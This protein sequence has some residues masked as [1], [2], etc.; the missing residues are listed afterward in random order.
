MIHE[1][2]GKYSILRVVVQNMFAISNCG[3]SICK[4][5]RHAYRP[6]RKALQ[7]VEHSIFRGDVLFKLDSALVE[8]LG[9]IPDT[10][11]KRSH[12]FPELLF[13]W[14]QVAFSIASSNLLTRTCQNKATSNILEIRTNFRTDLV[15]NDVQGTQND[16]LPIPAAIRKAGSR[17]F[18]HDI[19]N[20]RLSLQSVIFNSV[21]GTEKTESLN[22]TTEGKAMQK[23]HQIKSSKIRII[24]TDESLAYA[25]KHAYY[26]RVNLVWLQNDNTLASQ[27]ECLALRES[28]LH[29]IRKEIGEMYEN[30][31]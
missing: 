11:E 7:Y 27:D 1:L 23:K 30:G 19:V 17:A 2:S 4:H 21:N 10:A 6:R 5:S 28:G 24:S 9:K 18:P 15:C 13:D 16:A 3:C 22:T 12:H 26:A 25:Q 14:Q 8:R 29:K 31:D 20:H